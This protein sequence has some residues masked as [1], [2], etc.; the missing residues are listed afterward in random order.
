MRIIINAD[1]LG[2]SRDVNERVFSL[3]EA[4]KVTSATLLAN[5]PW[6]EQAASQLRSYPYASFGVHLNVT[7]FV[8]LSSTR[9]L[10]CILDSKGCFR[11]DVRAFNLDSSLR[12][13]IYREWCAQVNR[14]IQSG[15]PV[16]HFD[17]HH[18]VHTIPCLF[19]VLKR[20][21]N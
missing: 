14:V 7:E 17:S 3:I 6:Y 1:D 10:R 15:I 13:A 16:S 8:S 12:E 19:L 9:A 2:Y 21:Q 5:G 11:G 20:L 18:H 4:R